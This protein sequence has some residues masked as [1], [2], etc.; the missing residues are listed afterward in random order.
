MNRIC[1]DLKVKRILV[2][3]GAWGTF[4]VKKGLQPGECPELWNVDHREAVADIA[5]SYR[6]AG[7][8]MVSTNSFGGNRFKLA[9]FGL[10][11]RAAELN[12]AA[13]ALT[14]ETVG[15]NLHVFASMGSTGKILMMGDVSEEEIY[16]AFKEQAMA[17][18]RG[19]ADAC[20]IETMM[21]LDEAVLAIRAAREN[22]GLEVICT[23]TFDRMGD[24]TY[25]TMMGNTPE[26]I[27]AALIDAGAAII[28]TN[29]GQGPA[30]MIEIVRAMRAAA[31][32][33][34]IL[35]Q[36]NAGL[37]V[38]VGDHDEFP[39]T[40]EMM[41]ARVPDLMAA[42]ANIIGGCCGTT[43][44]HIRAIANAAHRM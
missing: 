23:F 42:G 19:G 24:G 15:P 28:G 43:P 36:A 3:D 39:E 40:P 22:T 35:V 41:A 34:P 30:G 31:P 20:C 12:E 10:A 37:P 38:R 1:D 33:T 5:R 32:D 9:H 4:L 14:R 7:S 8:D 18:E 25:R 17:L 16:D 11:H 27:A 21:A 6:D 13:A 29:C 2:S 44:D 26:E